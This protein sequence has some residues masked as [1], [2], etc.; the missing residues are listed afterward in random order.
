MLII[1][2]NII[3]THTYISIELAHKAREVAVFEECWE[4][5]T[6]KLR[7]LPHH[8]RRPFGIPWNDVVRGR[9]VHEHISLQQKRW[10]SALPS[11]FPQPLFTCSFHIF[12]KI[13][14]YFFLWC[15]PYLYIYKKKLVFEEE[16]EDEENDQ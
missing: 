15:L 4:E 14:C 9:I 10:W 11:T 12:K 5:I 13:F 8:E 2:C 1:E 3:H 7:W 16:E 6:S